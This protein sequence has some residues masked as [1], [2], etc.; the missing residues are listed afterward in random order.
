MADYKSS[1][2]GAEIE[3]ALL[4]AKDLNGTA[5]IIKADGRGNVATAKQGEDYGFPLL[6]GNGTPTANLS[7]SVGQHYFDIAA[8]KA[9]YEYVCVGVYS[10][11]YRW[12]PIGES[13]SGFVIR[14]YYA[15]LS[16]LQAAVPSPNV[17]DAYGVGT[18]E[19]YDI[20]VF[21]GVSGDWLNN[22]GLKGETGVGVIPH[23]AKGQVLGKAS[24][25]SYN[26]EWL[27]VAMI[28][29]DA[30]TDATAP[31]YV[32]QL[33]VDSTAT[34]APYMYV[35]TG[36]KLVSGNVTYVWRPVITTI[37]AG[38]ITGTMLA[39]NAVTTPKV[40]DK[41][42]TRA[43]LANDA[44]YS[45]MVGLVATNATYNLGIADLGKTFYTGDN[46]VGYTINLTQEVST[47]LPSGYAVAIFFFY[48]TG[49]TIVGDGVRFAVDGESSTITNGV[50][51]IS[52]RYGMIA[53]KKIF[54][55][56]SLGDLWSVQGRV[57]V[58]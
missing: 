49:V 25:D 39:N 56:A 47:T 34:A 42:M 2:K 22:G 7:G 27:D 10:G 5:G 43:K 4:T 26:T 14:G 36:T 41:S 1:L 31:D 17:G 8:E 21:D 50:L 24:D 19:N 6:R 52:A 16:A 46:T 48:G 28:G 53:L 12:L 58:V 11:G 37:E 51:K 9:P 57:E 55:S 54:N 33:Y 3:A 45:P 18:V 38:N 23:G 35:C 40:K 20:Y 15:T 32:G 13:G 30:P 44:L 29:E